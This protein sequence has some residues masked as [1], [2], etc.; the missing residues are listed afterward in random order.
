MFLYWAHSCQ[1]YVVCSI[2]GADALLSSMSVKTERRGDRR[3]KSDH[4][5]HDRKKSYFEKPAEAFYS[6]FN[7]FRTFP[8]K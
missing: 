1:P 7:V 4:D 2:Y 5:R 3:D 8:H 6:T